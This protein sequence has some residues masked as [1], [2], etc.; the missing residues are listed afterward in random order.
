[1]M[2]CRAYGTFQFISGCSDPGVE[3]PGYNT[4]RSYAT[5]LEELKVRLNYAITFSESMGY[6]RP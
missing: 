4:G 5:F 3:T 2:M 1:M 6:Y